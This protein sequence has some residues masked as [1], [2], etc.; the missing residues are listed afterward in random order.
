MLADLEAS[1]LYGSNDPSR[2]IELDAVKRA[3]ALAKRALE[4]DS[5]EVHS[6]RVLGLHQM[7]QSVSMSGPA[8]KE[9]M[10][11][12]LE[13]F[14][15]ALRE[16]GDDAR[17]YEQM[18]LAYRELA[19]TAEAKQSEQRAYE[20]S[21]RCRHDAGSC[22]IRD[23]RNLL[24]RRN[25]AGAKERA[26]DLI[27]WLISRPSIPASWGNSI[28]NTLALI[29][30]QHDQRDTAEELYESIRGNVSRQRYPQPAL[31]GLVDCNEAFLYV[32]SGRIPDAA[33][34]FRR[35][36]E[37][38]TSADCEAGL[39][40]ALKQL[41][42]DDEAISLYQSAR[43]RDPN[44]GNLGVLRKSYYWSDTA[45]SLAKSLGGEAP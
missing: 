45:L 12:A 18:S 27:R 36:L 15:V 20:L 9:M 6:H 4:Q 16:G 34:L 24:E 2:A 3:F 40:I 41:G 5:K 13:H 29:F 25:V 14:G 26:N 23:V 1:A 8:R 7:A 22:A 35:G 32:D 37:A 28:L 21:C 17:V 44:Y 43:K 19:Q 11:S 42:R 38:T 31:L 39:A 10:Q 30:Y 33:R